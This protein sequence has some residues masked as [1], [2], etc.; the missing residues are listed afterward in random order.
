[1]SENESLHTP[2]QVDQKQNNPKVFEFGRKP[3]TR[4]QRFTNFAKG[5]LRIGAAVST[6]GVGAGASYKAAEIG[7]D[8]AQTGAHQIVKAGEKVGVDKVSR[9][10]TGENPE[11]TSQEIFY[12]KIT[13]KKEAPDEATGEINST[14]IR[15]TPEIYIKNPNDG[16]NHPNPNTLDWENA[17]INGTPLKGRE[18]FFVTNPEIVHNDYGDWMVLRNVDVKIDGGKDYHGD[19]YVNINPNSV[20]NLQVHEQFD[21]NHQVFPT[22]RSADG[23]LQY[24]DQNGQPH[25]VPNSGEVTTV[26]PTPAQNP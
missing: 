4:L 2:E 6:I 1:M 20:G 21:P 23:Q 9:L 18:A 13:V 8:A 15:T 7:V 14:K 10:I 5:A 19:A 3:P 16:S 25:L 12:G 17:T 22:S 11:A 26:A 24:I